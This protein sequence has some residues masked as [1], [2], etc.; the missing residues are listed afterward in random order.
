MSEQRVGSHDLIDIQFSIDWDS[1]EGHHHET[2][3]FY[4]FHVWRDIDLLPQDIQSA[5]IDQQVGSQGSAK[6]FAGDN[7]PAKSSFNVKKARRKQFNSN[8]K[9]RIVEPFAGRFYPQDIMKDLSG[10]LPGSFL[11]LRVT[12]LDEQDITCDL[13]HPF[14]GFNFQMSSKVNAIHGTPDE[15]GGRCVDPMEMLTQHQGMQI[16]HQNVPTDFYSNGGFKRMDEV[17]D[18]AFY[19][20]SRM[21]DHLD[22]AALA[23]VKDLYAGLLPEN[24]RVLDLMSSVN[25]HLRDDV[26]TAHVTGL[27]MNLEELEANPRLDEKLVQDLNK[28]PRLPFDDDS[29]DAV[30]CTVS[31]EYLIDPVAVFEEVRRVLKP[32]GLFINTFS[33]RWFPPKVINLWIDLH[34]YERMGLVSDYYLKAG[35]FKDLHTWSLQGLQR[36][37]NDKY[38]MHTAD[39]DPLYAVWAYKA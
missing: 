13:N 30:L 36:P 4:N 31:V 29:F 37:E 26:K 32:G 14:A 35:G 12:D 38:S 27:G 1:D 25:S 2:R 8:F 20:M 22:A 17:A 34:E 16:R 5:I 11:P 21:T 24:A 6:V 23:N 33:N 18:T 10:V 19:S 15:H 39:A 28:T 7:V 3:H 9:G